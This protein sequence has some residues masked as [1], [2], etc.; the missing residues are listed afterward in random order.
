[1]N[2]NTPPLDI[3]ARTYGAVRDAV[4]NPD[5]TL[6]RAE[7]VAILELVKHE[8]LTEMLEEIDPKGHGQ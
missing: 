6:S 7:R 3:T 8:L 5:P 1:M 4:R 2:L